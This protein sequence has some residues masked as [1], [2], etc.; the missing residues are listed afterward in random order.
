[1][2]SSLAACLHSVGFEMP[3]MHDVVPLLDTDSVVEA[4]TRRL[5]WYSFWQSV[6]SSCSPHSRGCFMH[7]QAVVQALQPT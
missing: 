6:L 4:L 3:R 2:A 7:I 5:Q 1:M